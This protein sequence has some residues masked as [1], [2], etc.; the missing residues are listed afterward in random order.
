MIF[1]TEWAL[2][3]GRA[4]APTTAE[5][6]TLFMGPWILPFEVASVLLLV[7]MIGAVVLARKEI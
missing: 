1:G 6:G 7:A 5:I 3:D 4:P 2:G